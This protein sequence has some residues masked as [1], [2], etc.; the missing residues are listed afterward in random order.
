MAQCGDKPKRIAIGIAPLGIVSIDIVP[1]GVMSIGVVP[2]GVI[3][4]GVVG[5][6]VLNVCVVGMGV[7]IAGVNVMGVWWA[8]VEGM[9]SRRLGAS[10]APLHQHHHGSLGQAA[11]NLL[12]YPTRQQ[13]LKQAHQLG[14]SGVDSFGLILGLRLG[15]G[16][17]WWLQ[18]RVCGLGRLLG[19]APVRA[20]V[21]GPL[22]TVPRRWGYRHCGSVAVAAGGVAASPLAQLIELPV[23]GD[24][25]EQGGSGATIQ[26]LQLTV[27][28]LW[29][30]IGP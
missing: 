20:D 13:A 26:L 16:L 17:L 14:C 2:M 10:P 27:L 18:P 23:F 6:G 29:P 8:G 9:G 28:T 30:K 4:L 5:M 22:H 21:D 1:M 12:V 11:A 3:S 7:L 19:L 24:A 15:Q 25:A